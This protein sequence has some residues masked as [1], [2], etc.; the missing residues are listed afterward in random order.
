MPIRITC[1]EC[2]AVYD[3]AD[4]LGGKR[5][6]CAGCRSEIQ[7]PSRD[8]IQDQ[9]P[10]PA[11]PRKEERR[12]DDDRPR[13]RRLRL[14]LDDNE[15]RPRRPRKQQ[16]S[17]NLVAGLVLGG[18]LVF[19]C[20]FCGL[21]ALLRSSR[22][23]PAPVAFGPGPVIP[24]GPRMQEGGM[25]EMRRGEALLNQGRAKEA[26]KAFRSAI[27]SNFANAEAHCK[28]GL[29][30]RD[31]GRF[32]E[33]LAELRRGQELGFRGPGMGQQAAEWVEECKHFIDMDRRLPAILAGNA[34]P[35]D[36]LERV[37]YVTLA[38]YKQRP[39]TAARFAA[40]ILADDER[41][42]PELEDLCLYNGAC[43]AAR[44]AAGRGD[45]CRGLPDKVVVMLRHQAL[46]WLRKDLAQYKWRLEGGGGR[47][48]LVVRLQLEHWQ[49]DDDLTTVRDPNALRDLPEDEQRAWQALWR[50]VAALLQK[51][52][53]AR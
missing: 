45:D 38:I 41:L 24:P 37:E 44:A 29:A 22:P 10:P 40:A 49:V 46:R 2:R 36:D 34:E 25:K 6:L 12:T 13:R 21:A 18:V 43:G 27:D 14:E 48:L 32:T 5:V 1:P 23:K 26:E 20:G 30:L 33:A 51:V 3:L 42:A 28:L 19:A 50:D 39:A 11:Q 53:P 31:Q 35:A 15:G 7:V 47:A 17:S 16:S 8:A 4:H 52:P 9:P